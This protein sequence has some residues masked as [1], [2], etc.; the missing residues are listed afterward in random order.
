MTCLSGLKELS[1]NTSS[2]NATFSKLKEPAVKST[3][4]LTNIISLL[5][6]QTILCPK[7]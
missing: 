5:I 4:L 3:S 6:Q 2:R 7:P 1:S